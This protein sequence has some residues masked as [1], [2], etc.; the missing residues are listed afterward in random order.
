MPACLTDEVFRPSQFS[1]PSWLVMFDGAVVGVPL[2]KL[3]GTFFPFAAVFF[4]LARFDF[5]EAALCAFDGGV[6]LLLCGD[7]HV[8]LTLGRGL[9]LGDFPDIGRGGLG[10][11]RLFLRLVP[12]R[13]VPLRFV[14]RGLRFGLLLFVLLPPV[15]KLSARRGVSAV[16]GDH[17]FSLLRLNGNLRTLR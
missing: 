5:G 4:G 1:L 8:V 2:R 11:V 16:E 14:V 3:L 10:D 15:V 12:F 7:P 17:A 6:C 13:L 9:T